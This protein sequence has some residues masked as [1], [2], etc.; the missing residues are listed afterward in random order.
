MAL[1]AARKGERG[2]DKELLAGFN[3]RINALKKQLAIIQKFNTQMKDSGKPVEGGTSV[4]QVVLGTKFKDAF[5][6]EMIALKARKGMLKELNVTEFASVKMLDRHAT[7]LKNKITI[8][9][10]LNMLKEQGVVLTAEE[11]KQYRNLW[12]EIEKLNIK[13][14]EKKEKLNAVKKAAKD[15]TQGLKDFAESAKNLQKQLSDV[16]L[17]GLQKM[18]DSLVGLINKTMT[19]KEAFR[20]MAN[21]II[22]DLQ[23]MMIRKYITGPIAASMSSFIGGMQ[24]GGPVKANTP[25]IVGERGPELFMPQK[26]GSIVPNHQLGGGVNVVN[27]YDFSGAN[28]AT[29]QALRQESERIKQETFASVFSAVGRGGSYARAVGKR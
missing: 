26:S 13:L 2:T 15:N 18:E 16:A 20:S 9:Q 10:R 12:A 27:N 29:I 11:V 8:D 21:S 28:P 14:D 19:V 17:S 24:S 25:Y 1:E 22:Q 23:R 4:P 3:K 6:K 5:D 7:S